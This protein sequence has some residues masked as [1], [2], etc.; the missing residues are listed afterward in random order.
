ML[1]YVS[2]KRETYK[3]NLDVLSGASRLDCVAD[4]K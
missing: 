2:V 4:F 1:L 3:M